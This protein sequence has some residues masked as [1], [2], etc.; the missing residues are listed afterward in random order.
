MQLKRDPFGSLFLL[1][2]PEKNPKGFSSRGGLA[3]DRTMRFRLVAKSEMQLS[4]NKKVH[5]EACTEKR[6]LLLSPNNL[7]PKQGLLN[8]ACIFTKKTQTSYRY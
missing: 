6:M 4:S 5:A 3:T 2:K 7:T 1:S 8:R